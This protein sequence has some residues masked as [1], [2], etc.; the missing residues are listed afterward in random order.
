M[1]ALKISDS[2]E[3][4]LKQGY[5]A[6]QITFKLSNEERIELKLERDAINDEIEEIEQEKKEAL[7]GFKDA[8]KF[9]KDRRTP[10]SQAIKT[11]Y[12]NKE[13]LV[14]L[15]PN[16]DEGTMEYYNTDS[17]M[18]YDRPLK[19]SERQTTMIPHFNN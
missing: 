16:Y 1:A 17:I 19:P 11:G 5:R 9:K 3:S 10:I 12:I 7:K 6:E 14:T 4:F 8:I 15:S 18:V 2:E 13:I